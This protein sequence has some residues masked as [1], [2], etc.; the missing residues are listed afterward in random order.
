MRRLFLFTIAVVVVARPLNAQIAVYDPA[1]T[2]RNSITATV[3]EYLLETQREQHAQI[4]TEWRDGS[5]S[6][7]TFDDSSCSILRAGVRMVA[8]SSTPT[9]STTP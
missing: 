1:I 3:K 4:T 2:A 8:I 9:A 6:L 7:P 5:A